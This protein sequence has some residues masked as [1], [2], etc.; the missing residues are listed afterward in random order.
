MSKPRQ[1]NDAMAA[2]IA[3]IVLDEDTWTCDNPNIVMVK[4]PEMSHIPEGERPVVMLKLPDGTM[5]DIQT[6]N[7]PS[8]VKRLL[9]DIDMDRD[10]VVDDPN[11]DHVVKMLEMMREEFGCEKG[12]VAQEEMD[13]A[14]ILMTNLLRQKREN[15][16]DMSYRHLSPCI[17]DV[18]KEWDIDG[19]GTVA[20]HELTEAAHAYKKVKK[21]GRRMRRMIIGLCCVIGVLLTGMFVLSYVAADMAKEM[22]SS[23]DG[24]MRAQG[25]VVKVAS[26][27]FTLV[28]GQLVAR[29]EPDAPAECGTNTTCR[30]LRRG[31]G[32]QK[33]LQTAPATRRV[34]GVCSQSKR[35]NFDRLKALDF[36]CAQPLHLPVDKVMSA[37]MRECNCGLVMNIHTKEGIVTLDGCDVYVDDPMFEFLEQAQCSALTKKVRKR[38]AG[39]RPPP[40]RQ[41]GRQ[42]GRQLLGATD[43]LDG[44]FEWFEEGEEP[45]ESNP[46]P[47]PQS[48]P[49][50]F[51]AE[52]RITELHPDPQAEAFSQYF[53]DANGSA[54]TLPGIVSYDGKIYKTWTEEVVRAS[55]AEV[56]LK[57]Y[58]MH[59]LQ[60]ELHLMKAGVLAQMDLLGSRGFRC[61]I[62]DGDLG[63]ESFNF[64]WQ[65]SMEYQ[66]TVAEPD[67]RI[68]RH[69][70]TD[71]LKGLD[72]STLTEDENFSVAVVEAGLSPNIID[73]YDVDTDPSEAFQSGQPYRIHAFSTVPG[74]T[75]DR[76]TEYLTME[77]VDA[78]KGLAQVLEELG[79]S[80][81]DGD[82]DV[83]EDEDDADATADNHA[84]A[85]EIQGYLSQADDDDDIDEPPEIDPWAEMPSALLFNYEMLQGLVEEDAGSPFLEIATGSLYWTSLFTMADNEDVLNAFVNTTSDERRL[86]ETEEADFKWSARDRDGRCAVEVEADMDARPKSRTSQGRTIRKSRP[87]IMKMTAEFEGTCQAVMTQRS[88]LRSVEV[89]P[90]G[91]MCQRNRAMCLEKMPRRRATMESGRLLSEDSDDETMA[92]INGFFKR[93]QKPIRFQLKCK[94]R[95]GR[96]SC[97]L[98]GRKGRRGGRMLSGGRPG[99]GKAGNPA[100]AGMKWSFTNGQ[101]DTSCGGIVK[102]NM[103]ANGK[104]VRDTA[105]ELGPPCRPRNK[106]AVKWLR[107][108]GQ[109]R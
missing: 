65:P 94:E 50:Y 88:R 33:P 12:H 45:C 10:G 39:G 16:A 69:W 5:A 100:K 54:L 28:D 60:A 73:Y 14:L 29:G 87:L 26:S 89:E 13:K 32:F 106:K 1:P 42:G 81:L 19:D 38:Q 51:R 97:T 44:T 68:L 86:S 37:E 80:S 49:Q 95:K 4:M 56:H 3:P 90:A 30:R 84:L 77:A 104:P 6:M 8:N 27:D 2:P 91:E 66:G 43:I 64:S 102:A 11:V 53:S 48:I 58:A 25:E 22:R 92:K 41:G 70:R 55:D 46:L 63:T 35:S 107:R 85:A 82:C 76:M 67:G 23:G 17:Q 109:R 40:G 61:Q 18:M 78:S 83:D 103:W 24:V 47:D 20:L 101:F 75:V 96:T 98:R 52:V 57:R 72:L 9:S 71:V 34:E 21:E 59:P 99:R 105:K 74:S 36:R 93:K 62:G 79:V 7:L 31:G 108:G 15:S